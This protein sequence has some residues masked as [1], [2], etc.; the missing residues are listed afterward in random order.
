MALQIYA[1]ILTNT[2]KV[3]LAGTYTNYLVCAEQK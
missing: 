2:V 1:E 3:G